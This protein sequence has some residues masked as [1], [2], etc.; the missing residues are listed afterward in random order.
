[1]YAILRH[2]GIEVGKRDFIG[3]I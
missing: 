1:A 2:C 3:P